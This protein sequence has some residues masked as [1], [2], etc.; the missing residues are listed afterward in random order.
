MSIFGR[1]QGL[2]ITFYAQ[3]NVSGNAAF[4]ILAVIIPLE[5]LIQFGGIYMILLTDISVNTTYTNI[6]WDH[7]G[8]KCCVLVIYFLI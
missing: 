6:L 8:F 2:L 1:A 7:L 3:L 5:F 4:G